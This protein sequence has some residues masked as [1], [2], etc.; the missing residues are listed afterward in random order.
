MNTPIIVSLVSSAVL[1]AVAAADA[2]AD[3]ATCYA[4]GE[5]AV[6]AS[7]PLDRSEETCDGP[8]SPAPRRNASLIGQSDEERTGRR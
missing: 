2:R 1:A 4:R 7:A 5:A 6:A 3:D 8:P